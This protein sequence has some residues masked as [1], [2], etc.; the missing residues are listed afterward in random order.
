MSESEIV[1]DPK[2]PGPEVVAGFRAAQVLKQ[3]QEHLLHYFF[4]VVNTQ[5]ECHQVAEKALPELLEQPDHLVFETAL[6]GD[7]R[8]HMLRRPRGKVRN[9]E[10]RIPEWSTPGTL[11]QA[12]NCTRK[13]P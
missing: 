4:P 1:G 8:R 2:N 11:V 10:G 7:K 13:S 12:S 5:A 3:R 9:A 6:A